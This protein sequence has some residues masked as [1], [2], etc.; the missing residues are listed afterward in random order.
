MKTTTGKIVLTIAILAALAE[1]VYILMGE[2]KKNNPP[3]TESTTATKDDGI[4][5]Y[6]CSMHPQVTSPKPGK[7]PICG[8]D[9]TPVY[10]G[11]A[12]GDGVVQID[13]QMVQNIGV[14]TEVVMKRNLTHTIRTTGIVDYDETKQSYITIK[15][16]GYIENLYVNYIGKPVQRGQPLFDIYSPELVAAQQEYLQAISYK[17]TMNQSN[18]S[19]VMNGAET[20]IQSAKHKLLYLDITA[21]QIQTLERTHEIKKTLTIY[22]PFSGSVIEK[23][24]FDGMQVQAGMNLFK[25]ADVSQMWVYAD[26]YTNELAWVKTGEPVELELPYNAGK[27]LT[28]KISFISSS[29]Q[30][31]SRTSKVR[32]EFPNAASGLKKDMYVMVNIQPSDSMNVISVPEQSV[33]H[34][35]KRDIV[36]VSLGSGKF[37]S[38]DVKLGTLANNYYQV[39]EGL[40]EGDTIVTS[41]QFLI[42]SESSLKAGLS[43]MNNTNKENNNSMPLEKIDEMKKEEMTA[44]SKTKDGVK[45][46]NQTITPKKVEEVIDPVCGMTVTTDTKLNYTYKGTTYY[47]CAE[48]ELEDFKKNPETFLNKK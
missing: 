19:S 10:K 27:T 9:L 22:S 38:V 12:L 35:G 8:M 13:P 32:I 25:L 6:H 42:D 37:K 1:G 15:F 17:T 41:S 47:F 2:L 5:Y 39:I 20:L 33:I 29:I 34:S 28:G 43:G 16:S 36:V 44:P 7:C 46:G 26:V 14:K 31:Q 4:E 21:S 45:K 48:T 18:D 24:V 3:Q 30:D 11:T 40:N 23:N